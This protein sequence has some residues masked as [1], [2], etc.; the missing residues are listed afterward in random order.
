MTEMSG[1][2]VIA[3]ENGHQNGVKVDQA[4]SI[5]DFIEIFVF[6]FSPLIRT[7]FLWR[8]MEWRQNSKMGKY[9]RNAPVKVIYATLFKF[10]FI[11]LRF[12]RARRTSDEK[13][14]DGR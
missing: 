9:L 11:I 3:A 6:F 10:I 8:R 12:R 7:V 4:P 2:E 1:D 14:E 5:L 13:V